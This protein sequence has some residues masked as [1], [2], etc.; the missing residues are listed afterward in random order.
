MAKKKKS[1]DKH[2]NFNYYCDDCQRINQNFV[3]KN[4]D[5][6]TEQRFK[7]SRF[8][9]KVSY[10]KY[11]LIPIVVAIVISA[12]AVFWLWPAWF[13]DMSLNAQLYNNKAGGLDY[14]KFYFL[15]GWSTNFIFNWTAL[16]GAFMGSAIMSLPPERNLL[17]LIGTKLRFGKP[18]RGKSLLF[19]WTIGFVMFYFLGLLLNVNSGGFSWNLY[20]IENGDIAL[21]PNLILDAFNVIFNQNNIDFVTIYIYSNLLN[22]F[23]MRTRGCTY[24]YVLFGRDKCDSSSFTLFRIFL[25]YR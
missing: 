13:G 14:F 19:W 17:T 24:T 16:I 18:T 5:R 15:N 21:T 4:E 9:G 10:R 8:K 22:R 3:N 1:C 2:E 12:I 25:G 23:S 20:L 6:F 11:I 7:Y